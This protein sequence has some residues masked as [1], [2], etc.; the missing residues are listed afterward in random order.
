MPKTKTVT[1]DIFT[2]EELSETAKNTAREWYRS[3]GID[4]E[5]WESTYEDAENIGLKIS[6]FDCGRSNEIEIDLLSGFSISEVCQNI[7]KDHGAHCETYKTA[8]SLY[9]DRHNGYTRKQGEDYKKEWLGCI[10]E[11]YLIMLRKDLEYLE[12][13][14]SVDEN[15]KCNE[16][17]FDEN[18]KRKD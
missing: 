7:L 10:G 8:L 16:Y 18:G 2:F 6:S 1:Y 14:E 9:I 5:W 11:D 15:I 17:T 13:D 4:F 12:S 3:L